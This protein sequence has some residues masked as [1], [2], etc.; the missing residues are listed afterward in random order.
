MCS[1]QSLLS[2]D[3]GP[4][5]PRRLAV[6]AGARRL[7]GYMNGDRI[8]LHFHDVLIGNGRGRKNARN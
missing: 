6:N 5:Q 4:P 7:A 3:L 8:A 1:H 2:L